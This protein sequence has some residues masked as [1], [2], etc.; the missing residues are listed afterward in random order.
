VPGLSR[1]VFVITLITPFIAFAPHTADA[2]P[3]T[4]SMRFTSLMF[5]GMKSHIVNPKKSW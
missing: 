5:T 3:R 1:G 2:G 4:T